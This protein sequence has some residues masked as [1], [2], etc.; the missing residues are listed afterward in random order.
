MKAHTKAKYKGLE[1][2]LPPR[3]E[4]QT[5]AAYLSKLENPLKNR[6]I[7]SAFLAQT[8]TRWEDPPP[9]CIKSPHFSAKI[10]RDEASFAIS[11]PKGNEQF[12]FAKRQ[13]AQC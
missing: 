12:A 9:F 1:D 5:L 3:K 6:Q 2:C 10:Q 4:R 8:L 11:D 7:L 13:A